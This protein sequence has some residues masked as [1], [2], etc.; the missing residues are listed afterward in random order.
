M[1]SRIVLLVLLCGMQLDGSYAQGQGA[2]G[3]CDVIVGLLSPDVGVRR[4]ARDRVI[5]ERKKLTERV[6]TELGAEAIWQERSFE[7]RLHTLL[8]VARVYR[9]EG[10]VPVIVGHIDHTLDP[11]TFPLMRF[12]T[13]AYYPAARALGAIG[14]S[15]VLES[16]GPVLQRENDNV[17]LRA[18]LWVVRECLGKE[19]AKVWISGVT[20]DPERRIAL[21]QMLAEPV[22]LASVAR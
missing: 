5:A 21:L 22:I 7:G 3:G 9:L 8:A 15:A 6:A 14:G 11:R 4:G 12:T 17:R 19:A 13:D 16:L 10:T 2:E 18:C 1:R 20:T